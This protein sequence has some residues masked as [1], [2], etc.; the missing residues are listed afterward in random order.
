MFFFDMHESTCLTVENIIPHIIQDSYNEA[1]EV[2]ALECSHNM[3]LKW[4][5]FEAC[6]LC[7]KRICHKNIFL[8]KEKYFK[9]RWPLKVEAP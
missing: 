8:M 6:D 2:N 5:D 1:Q 9:V 4:K 3:F 7:F